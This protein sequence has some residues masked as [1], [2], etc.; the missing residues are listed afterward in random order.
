LLVPFIVLLSLLYL[1]RGIS[2]AVFAGGGATRT[3]LPSCVCVP[4]LS[5]EASILCSNMGMGL[6]PLYHG[7]VAV[8]M[9]FVS[10]QASILCS[11]MGFVCS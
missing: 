1:H 11:N 5:S 6:G 4:F 2:G 10:S 9:P 3:P 8:C 7:M